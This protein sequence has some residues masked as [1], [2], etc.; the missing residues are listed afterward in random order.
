MTNSAGRGWPLRTWWPGNRIGFH[1]KRV[2]AI[3]PAGAV[4]SSVRDLARWLTFH[5]TRSPGL[6]REDHWRD[7][8]RP[9]AEMPAPDQPE[10]QH[11]S[12]A[13]AWI[14]ESYRGHPLV[15]H[16][17]VIDGY[18]VHLGLLPETGHG[19]ILLM[20]R[21]LATATL[22]ALA[23][24][25]YDHLLGLEPLDWETRLVEE[26]LPPLQDV[27]AVPLDFPLSKVAGGY[28]HRAYGP[29][30]VRANGDQLLMQ[31]RNF[32]FTLVYQ[33]KLGFLSQEPI[34]DGGPQISVRF[35]NP[36]LDESQKLF[37]PFN[38]D[39][40]DPVQVFTRV[41]EVSPPRR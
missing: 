15:V 1:T 23:Y 13:L 37:V 8:H 11:P 20:N 28:E 34:L 31:F 22:M 9:Q 7:L 32:R 27:P 29:L 21:D 3:A 40:D 24:S 39:V 41:R 2:S 6:L 4:S 19:L 5:A 25:A 36:R 17:G 10:V 18:T 33:G 35:S 38:F 30:T 26:T 12:Y 14:Y 16:N